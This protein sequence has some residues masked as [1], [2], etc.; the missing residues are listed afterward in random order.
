MAKAKTKKTTGTKTVFIGVR[1][2]IE[3]AERLKEHAKEMDT[4]LSWIMRGIIRDLCAVSP[5][6][7]AK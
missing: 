3:H 4:S 1:V 2:P 6:V 5:A 7:T